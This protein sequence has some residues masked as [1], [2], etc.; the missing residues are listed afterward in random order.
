MAKKELLNAY[1]KAFGENLKKIRE[2]KIKTLSG[3]DS[4]TKFDSSNYHKYEI[5]TGNP[6]LETIVSIATG[7]DVHPKE[8]LN[9]DFDL[10]NIDIHK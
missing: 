9:F 7:L 1:K 8:L 5:G 3:V 10:K 6:T 4:R 2:E